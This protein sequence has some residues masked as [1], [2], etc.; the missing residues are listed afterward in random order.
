MG[1]TII[2]DDGCFEWDEGKAI[3]NKKKHGI[4]FEKAL[5]VF[6]DPRKVEFRDESHFDHEER[7]ITIGSASGRTVL[8]VV[9][10]S[11]ERNGRN[12]LISARRASKIDEG[13]YY[14]Q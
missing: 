1:R 14:G 3:A 8:L 13:I 10:C 9:V 6:L 5:P 7:Y 2:S 11:T 12:R 4:A